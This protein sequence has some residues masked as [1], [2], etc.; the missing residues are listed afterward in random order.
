MLM[1]QHKAT[2]ETI[3][4]PATPQG[5]S[6]LAMF[7]VSGPEA[8]S[9]T[10]R[11][12]KEKAIFS[13]TPARQIQLFIAIDPITKNVIDQITGI[14]YESPKSFTGENMVEIICHGGQ[15]IIKEI[16]SALIK[17]GA[18]TATGG[19]FT[20]RALLNGKISIMKAEAIRGLIESKSSTE[21]KCA[22][23][24]FKGTLPELERWRKEVMALLESVEAGIE[25][26]E[27]GKT[28]DFLRKGEKKIHTFLLHLTNDLK[29]REKII[30]I[31]NGIRVVIAGPVNAGK[32]TLFNRMVGK[33]R[34]I[35]HSE[36]GTTRDVVSE[37]LQLHGHEIQLFDSA[38]IRKTKHEIEREGIKISRQVIREAGI[39]IWV[40]AANEEMSKDECRELLSIAQNSIVICVINKTDI[41]DSKE[42]EAFCL[43]A[44]IEKVSISLK[45]EDNKKMDY[46]LDQIYSKLEALL[47]ETETP[48]MIL[49]ARHEEIGKAL[50]K[51]ILMA[52]KEWKRPEIAAFHLK[53]GLSLMEEF[54]GKVNSEEII[55]EIFRDFC[56]GK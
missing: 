56:I 12:I 14:K 43:N 17:A 41:T 44:G 45:E 9:I 23:K 36:P 47:E 5:K 40:T 2:E 1:R 31:G 13:K 15:Q 24:M 28:E 54:F 46:L 16:F 42:K 18:R 37:N 22:R 52:K 50:H 11:C 55:N 10:S 48:E 33:K 39:V 26:D 20:R 53:K 29:K 35:V 8:F 30:I 34:S 25:F 32:S 6:A 38:G 7:R 19:E 21:L 4:A 49:N 3:V 51:E 27:T